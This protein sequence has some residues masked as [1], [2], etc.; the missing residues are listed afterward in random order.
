MSANYEFEREIQKIYIAYYGRA[1]D[2]EGQQF[3]AE[4]L[5]SAGGDLTAI[6][7]AF[8][9]SAEFQAVYAGQEPEQLINNLFQQLF[10]RDADD[11]GLGFYQ[12]LLENGG[13]S[14]ASISLDILKGAQ[15]D[16]L[17]VVDN[18]LNYVEEFTLKIQLKNK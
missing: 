9:N 12:D 16:D 3:W 4:Q 15:N 13:K 6:V 10:G 1:A 17:S 5:Q 8:G 11:E 7:D 14:L 2:P 18:K